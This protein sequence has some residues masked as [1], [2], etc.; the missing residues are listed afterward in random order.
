M[1]LN[2]FIGAQK[3]LLVEKR[4]AAN[5]YS[6]FQNLAA[7]LV[8]CNHP[9]LLTLS[10]KFFSFLFSRINYWSMSMLYKVS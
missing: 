9:Q 1:L 10:L 3:R 2:Y 8:N 4:P 6:Y 5:Y 7:L